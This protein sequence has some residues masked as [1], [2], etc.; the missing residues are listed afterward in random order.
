MGRAEPYVP[1]ALLDDD[2]NKRNLTI[3]GVRV[4]GDRRNLRA[5]AE[6]YKAQALVIAVPTGDGAL[7]RELSDLARDVG[8]EVRVVP[9]VRELLGGEVHVDDLRKPTEAD[10]LG[11]H[12]VE[13]DLHAVAEYIT[14]KRVVVTGAGGSI[15]SELCRQL[16]AFDPAALVMVDRDESGLHSVQL[17]LD[18]RAMLDSDSLVLID[19]RDRARVTRLFAEIKP[20]VVFH[21]AALKHLPLLQA[22]PSEA[23]KSNVWGTLSVLDAAAT[24]E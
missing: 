24:P 6:E 14:G 18:G 12:K 9:S 11:R 21:A 22:H 15:G 2:P 23:L 5:V 4:I 19:I 3:R 17:S 20:D 10:L 8:L 13:T 1:V 7:V 16:S